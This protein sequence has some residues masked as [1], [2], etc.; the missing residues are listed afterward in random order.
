VDA[1]GNGISAVIVAASFGAPFDSDQ[2]IPPSARYGDHARAAAP[3]PS[4]DARLGIVRQF[5]ATIRSL[6]PANFL[7]R[8]YS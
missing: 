7:Y 8:D 2:E 1:A 5:A 3:A 4:L 6:G